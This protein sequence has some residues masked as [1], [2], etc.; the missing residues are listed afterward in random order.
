MIGKVLAAFALVA[1]L[2]SSAAWS[3]D[4]ASEIL[5]HS[6][7]AAGLRYHEAKAV[8]DQMQAGDEVVLIRERDSPHD[9]NAVRLEWNGH[10]LGYLPRSDNES[11]ARQLDRGNALKARIARL[12]K[13]RNHRLKLDVDIY[14][15][16]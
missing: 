11:V 16:L 5:V 7:L 15:P 2:A 4:V 10:M 6:T 3:G 9:T 12:S 13:Y 8:W 14:L 1:G